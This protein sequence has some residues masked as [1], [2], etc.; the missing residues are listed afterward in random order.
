M[1]VRK[2]HPRGTAETAAKARAH[3]KGGRPGGQQT[4]ISLQLPE[5]QDRPIQLLKD[6][7][8]RR[9]DPHSISDQ[10]RRSVMLVLAHGTYTAAELGDLLGVSPQT[11]R[12]DMRLLRQQV[13]REVREWTPEDVVGDLVLAA[14]RMGARAMQQ[15]DTALAWK[16]RLDLARALREAGLTSGG[17]EERRLKVTVEAIETGMGDFRTT[18]LQALD[19]VLSGLEPDGEEL[20]VLAGPK[21]IG[22][23]ALGRSGRGRGEYVCRSGACPGS[24]HIPSRQVL[25][26]ETGFDFDVLMQVYDGRTG[27]LLHADNFKDFQTFEGSGADPVVGMF[28]NLYAIEDRI[29]GIFIQKRVETTRFLYKQ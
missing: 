3:W 23:G 14:D 24:A 15:N 20:K 13:G 28:E 29:V 9:V 18:M 8:S 7:R 11:I 2:R 4:G 26:E 27:A 25:V 1:T 22:L 21:P 12:K 6:I 19:P 16:I 5:H 17:Q 10:Q